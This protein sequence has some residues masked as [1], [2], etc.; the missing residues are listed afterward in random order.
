MYC[1]LGGYNRPI[2]L[3][4]LPSLISTD[5]RSSS[6]GGGGGG[7]DFCGCSLSFSIYHPQL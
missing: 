6:S 4:F 1:R 7:V 3:G 2:Y 5:Q